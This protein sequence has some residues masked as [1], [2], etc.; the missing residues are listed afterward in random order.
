MSKV[1]IDEQALTELSGYLEK[2]LS[3][4]PNVRRPG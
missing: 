2:T 4:D 3:P 1:N